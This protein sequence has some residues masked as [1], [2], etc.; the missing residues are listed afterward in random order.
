ME[1]KETA[2]EKQQ[3]LFVLVVLENRSAD[4]SLPFHSELKSALRKYSDRF[5]VHYDLQVE[6]AAVVL[7]FPIVDREMQVSI[8]CGG[9]LKIGPDEEGFQIVQPADERAIADSLYGALNGAANVF[10]SLRTGI[11]ALRPVI[12]IP[13]AVGVNGYGLP[14]LHCDDGVHPTRLGWDV[15]LVGIEGWCWRR[16]AWC[17]SG[18]R[19]RSG[20]PIDAIQGGSGR[21]GGSLI[22][23]DGGCDLCLQLSGGWGGWLCRPTGCK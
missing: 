5:L 1:Q 20:S 21:H 22:S 3:S 23:I 17:G 8:L 7:A 14:G 12:G 18:E 4:F 13:D 11:A 19:P 6:R 2:A 10:L 15:D 16:C 9:E